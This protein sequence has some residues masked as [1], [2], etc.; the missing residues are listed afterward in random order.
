NVDVNS[1]H[2]PPFVVS[3]PRLAPQPTSIAGSLVAVDANR[4]ARNSCALM[5]TIAG[6]TI[7]CNV[8]ARSASRNASYSG[9]GSV[10][11]ILRCWK[12]SSA[13][14][15]TC[16]RCSADVTRYATKPTTANSMS[17]KV[18]E[19]A[20]VKTYAT[21]RGD[22]RHFPRIAGGSAARTDAF[23]SRP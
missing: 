11:T 4:I 6:I 21:T 10:T 5:R 12:Y 18:T 9:P 22:L 7:R 14:A 19:S 20:K 17:M 3:V 13:I 23:D 8:L 2:H 1:R 15:K 16:S